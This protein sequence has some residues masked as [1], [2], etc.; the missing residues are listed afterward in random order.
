[1]ADPQSLVQE[2]ECVHSQFA[3]AEKKADYLLD[4]ML[5]AFAK[6]TYNFFLSLRHH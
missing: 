3:D 6:D 2:V 4:S 5:S 1:M